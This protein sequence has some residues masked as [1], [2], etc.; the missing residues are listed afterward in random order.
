MRLFALQHN[1]VCITCTLD[2][3][4]PEQD[5][6]GGEEQHD[7][8]SYRHSG[9]VL[10]RE[11]CQPPSAHKVNDN[12]LIFKRLFSTALN[13]KGYYQSTIFATGKAWISAFRDKNRTFLSCVGQ[14]VH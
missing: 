13:E 1:K 7:T 9:H 3:D 5:D 12:L 6:L 8:A 14:I 10:Q 11:S 4:V 2:S